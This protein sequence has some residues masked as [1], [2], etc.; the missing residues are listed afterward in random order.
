MLYLLEWLEFVE[1]KELIAVILIKSVPLHAFMK[2]EQG[3]S[4][5]CF[6]ATVFYISE[7]MLKGQSWSY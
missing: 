4:Q 3:V 1:I 2:V 5:G 7:I 6:G